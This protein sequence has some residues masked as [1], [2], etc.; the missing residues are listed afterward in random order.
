MRK[1]KRGQTF[2]G[3]LKRLFG[4]VDRDGQYRLLVLYRRKWDLE[5]CLEM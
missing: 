1:V 2:H 5:W 3:L 4:H